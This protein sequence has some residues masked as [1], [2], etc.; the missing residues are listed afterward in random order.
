[1]K[2]KSV[3]FS[4]TDISHKF[5]DVSYKEYTMNPS[6]CNPKNRQDRIRV[7]KKDV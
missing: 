5:N 2:V 1:M 6:I 4:N 3:I 7:L